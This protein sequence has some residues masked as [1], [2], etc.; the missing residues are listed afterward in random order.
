MKEYE[1][2][3]LF[4]IIKNLSDCEIP[5]EKALNDKS[6]SSAKDA[7]EMAMEERAERSGTLAPKEAIEAML[8]GE[9]LVD[10]K[11]NKYSFLVDYFN[12]HCIRDGCNYFVDVFSGLRN[13]NQKAK[14]A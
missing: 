12:C 7:Y 4:D 13:P 6:T 14:E 3:N 9:T 8:R 11:G 2:E 10:A 5:L 1:T